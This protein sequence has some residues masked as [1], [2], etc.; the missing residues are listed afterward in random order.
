MQAAGI[1]WY[2]IDTHNFSSCI[3][4]V[5]VCTRVCMPTPVKA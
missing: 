1:M 2:A 5:C 4:V 3:Y